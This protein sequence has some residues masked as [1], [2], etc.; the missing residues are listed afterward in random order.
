MI[1]FINENSFFI[2][3]K[4]LENPKNIKQINKL[5][6]DF[7]MNKELN[8]RFYIDSDEIFENDEVFISEENYEL[9]ITKKK[10]KIMFNF[11]FDLE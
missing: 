6:T 8:E 7:L 10:N 2:E 4:T 1:N 5:I 3:S 9:E 11:I